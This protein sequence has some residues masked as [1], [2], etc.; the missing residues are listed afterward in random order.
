MI[1]LG[2]ADK[3]CPKLPIFGVYIIEGRKKKLIMN[4][5]SGKLIKWGLIIF[6][7][8]L[9]TGGFFA[10]MKTHDNSVRQK[11]EAAENT[12]VCCETFIAGGKIYSLNV[13]EGKV[14]DP[15]PEPFYAL[16]CAGKG[17]SGILLL[18]YHSYAW[19]SSVDK[20]LY[21]NGRR[22]GT[23][24]PVTGE[25]K[26]LMW[27]REGSN[28]EIDGIIGEYAL[29]HGTSDEQDL[30]TRN[31][32]YVLMN[33]TTGSSIETEIDCADTACLHP[34]AV[35][36]KNF[37]YWQD[38]SDQRQ[39]SSAAF[40]RYNIASGTSELIG[41]TDEQAEG[42]ELKV[43]EACLLNGHIYIAANN[44]NLMDLVP[45]LPV[46]MLALFGSEKVSRIT[47][48]EGSLWV[49]T[50]RPAGAD[51]AYTVYR[52]EPGGSP[53]TVFSFTDVKGDA[54]NPRTPVRL[55]VTQDAVIIT[56]SNWKKSYV[57]LQKRWSLQ[58]SGSSGTNSGS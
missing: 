50:E 1:I 53:E 36:E 15:Q 4:S 30:E 46:K 2:M 42:S 19:C 26:V 25:K 5:R 24:D 17:E 37:Y 49:L 22:V 21:T 10:A 9:T 48:Y 7:V 34:V 23:L 13:S 38:S 40:Y 32:K 35:D 16:C 43:N 33:V 52:Y 20:L 45:S 39:D 51:A 31:G 44:G 57:R 41:E 56:M 27:I 3:P 58:L 6:A 18:R 11:K 14:S 55:S 47:V 54:E 29:I 8:L 12:S 28:A